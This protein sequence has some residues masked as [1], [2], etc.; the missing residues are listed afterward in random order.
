MADATGVCYTQSGK[1]K[2]YES[3]LGPSFD[4]NTI[5]AVITRT[6]SGYTSYEYKVTARGYDASNRGTKVVVKYGP[7]S[8][9]AK[10][11]FYFVSAYKF[12]IYGIINA[13][14]TGSGSV[15]AFGGHIGFSVYMGSVKAEDTYL[16]YFQGNNKVYYNWSPGQKIT[17]KFYS[18]RVNARVAPG[19]FTFYFWVG[20]SDQTYPSMFDPYNYSL[21]CNAPSGQMLYDTNFRKQLMMNNS[22]NKRLEFSISN[23]TAPSPSWQLG[24]F[25]LELFS[26]FEL[27][28]E[29]WTMQPT[30]TF[31][32]TG[33]SNQYSDTIPK[34]DIDILTRLQ[35]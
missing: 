7:S 13:D 30:I 15:S 11:T 26:G 6:N 23:G 29:D 4:T 33:I 10:K 16:N 27:D 25:K 35:N 17:I 14:Q 34:Y 12:Y 20:N 21:T 8:A 3:T 5:S 2:R 32:A 31:S 19:I 22:Y 9:E 24:D 18:Y 28:D 1:V